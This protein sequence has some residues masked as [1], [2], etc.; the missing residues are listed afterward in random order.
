MRSFLVL[1]LA[2]KASGKDLRIHYKNSF[3]V[4]RAV[5]GMSLKG[6]QKYLKDVLAHKRCV[7]FTK[8]NGHVGRCA[9]ATEFGYSQGLFD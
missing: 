5:R 2:C 6:A 3:E 4:A 7:P 8:F 9:Q 1:L